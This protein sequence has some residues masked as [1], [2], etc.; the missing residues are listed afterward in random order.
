MLTYL[1]DGIILNLPHRLIIISGDNLEITYK[2]K[3]IE[4]ECTDPKTSDKIYGAN[5]TEKLH[6]R[7]D[8]ISA[9]DS[10]EE[11]LEF[12][13]GRCH[14]LT[15]N[16]KGQFAV[17]LIH[18]YRLIFTKLGNNIQIAHIIEIVDYH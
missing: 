15:N 3:K 18:P 6:L 5:M 10:V 8:Q 1:F 2:N 11:M 4:K 14:A 7:I 9:A 17:D 16:R 13:I 12:R